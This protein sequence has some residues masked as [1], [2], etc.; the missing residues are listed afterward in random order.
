[1]ILKEPEATTINARRS[2]RI[3]IVR[4]E[5]NVALSM[6]VYAD[7]L[8]VELRAIR[9]DWEFIEI[10]PQPWSKNTQ[11]L[12]H[13]GNP[14]RKYYER[15]WHHPRQV[16]K[17]QADIFHIIDHTN[18]HVA[19]WLKKQGKPV[20]ITCHDLVQYVY[21]EILRDQA[22]IPALSLAMWQYSV[23]G[24]KIAQRAIAVSQHTARDLT[25]WL[26]VFPQSVEVVPNGVSQEFRPLPV[27]AVDKWRSQYAQEGEICLLN[28]GSSHQ[29]KNLET[30]LQVVA[31]LAEQGRRVRL[32]KLG[33]DFTAAQQQF[34]SDRHLSP[35]IDYL[36]KPS[37]EELVLFYNAADVLVAPSLYEG[38]GLTVLEAMACGTPTIVSN[39]SA[40]PEVVGE[41]GIQV[42]PMDVTVIAQAICQLQDNP[43]YRHN[44]REAGLAQV[45]QFSWR[46]AAQK[47]AQIYEELA[48]TDS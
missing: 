7:N 37:S 19:Y 4:R 35:Y 2:L 30:V 8:L 5:P 23:K 33:G 48:L 16:Q 28:V 42:E 31:S 6:D 36:G 32:W 26:G 47:L 1:M 14:L 21:P 9:P 18:G 40:L 29:R 24:L 38:F 44:V 27:S 46:V 22:K 13:T 41:A 17:Q 15:F 11:D 10:A 20:V 39:V 34:I 12:W 45:Q 25:R 3:A 43:V